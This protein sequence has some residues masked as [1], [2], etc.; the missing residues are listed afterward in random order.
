[1]EEIGDKIM[2]QPFEELSGQYSDEL[3]RVISKM[4]QKNPKNRCTATSIVK[5]AQ[6]IVPEEFLTLKAVEKAI[7]QHSKK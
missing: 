6:S 1:M 3:K 2:N 7:K 5:K 4:L